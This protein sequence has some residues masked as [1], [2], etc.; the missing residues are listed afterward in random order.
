[1]CLLLYLA[2]KQTKP[3]EAEVTLIRSTL[4]FA[5]LRPW[6]ALPPFGPL[7]WDRSIPQAAV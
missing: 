2:E 5:G 6:D 4:S 1:M 7:S 3:S